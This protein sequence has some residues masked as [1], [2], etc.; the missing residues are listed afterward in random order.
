MSDLLAVGATGVRAYQ[1]ALS[2]V[3]DNIANAGTAGYTRRTTTLREV[4]SISARAAISAQTGNGVRVATIDRQAD[5]LRAAAVRTAG[6]D[7]AKTQTS[8]T[9][10]EAVEGALSQNTLGDSL[11][12]FYNSAKAVSADPTASVPRAAFI[13]AGVTV[14]NAFKVTGAALDTAAGDLGVQVQS[15]VQQLN[16][17]A[18]SLGKV[19][20]GLGRVQP[21]TAAAAQLL[22][23]RDQLLEQIGAL[24]NVSVATDDI[25]RVTVRLGDATGP[26]LLSGDVPGYVSYSLS[27]SG[28]VSYAVS[29]NG[30]VSALTPTGGALAGIADGAQRIA[31]A[32]LALD[33][34]AT[35][36][37]TSVNT[38]QTSGRDL[39][40]IA[41]TPLFTTGADPTD[42]S[43]AI[44]DPRKIAAAAVGG[45]PRDN[46]NIASLE[47][48]RSSAGVESRLTL[49]I[50]SNA[51]TLAARRQVADAQTTIRDGAVAARDTQS[52]VNLDNE[53]VDLMRYQQAY[54]AS[55]RV[56]QA[57]QDIF[58]TLLN[59]R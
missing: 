42:I 37:T 46:S 41:G 2:T 11:T 47:T 12:A 24:S 16:G 10:L 52:G 22:D 13:E 17:L 48:A 14:A 20:D 30:A 40:G 32:R 26:V 27:A 53:A 35:D 25:G 34:I 38:V 23:Q 50:S 4:T 9:W 44:T 3:S 1:T 31:D 18:D 59:L 55:S 39:D 54:Q 28:A 36:F 33:Q 43:V 7:L 58:N 56:I 8:I 15:A 19:N 6:S 21:G 5:D 57:A 51:S 49:L 29:R 45:G